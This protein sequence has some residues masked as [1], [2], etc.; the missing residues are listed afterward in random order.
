MS[1]QGLM[2]D[3]PLL[4]SSLIRYAAEQH[5]DREVVARSCEG[6]IHRTSWAEVEA[7]GRRLAQALLALGVGEG[8]RVATL[9]WNTHRHLEC[10]YG[11][12][13][14]GAVL[15][16]VNPRLFEEQIEYIVRHAQDRV[17][18][19]DLEFLPLVEK[20]AAR[21]SD[22]RHFVA[23]CEKQDLPVGST[24]AGLLS[25][26]EILAARSGDFTWPDFDERAASSLC[27]T[28]GTTGNP[29]GVLYSHRSTVL[30]ALGANQ[31][32]VFCLR[33]VDC[34]LGM[35]PLYHANGWAMPYVLPLAG[36]KYVLPGSKLEPAACQELIEGEAV[37]AAFAVPT[38]WTMMLGYLAQSGKRIESLERTFI[39]GTAVSQALRDAY[40]DEHGVEVVHLWG[41]T[42][43][44]PLGTIGTP[45]ARVAALPKE[46]RDRQLLKQGRIPFGVKM[47]IVGGDGREVQRD[48]QDFG[49]M[50]V[51]GPWIASGYFKGE[52]G[53]VLDA[54]GWFPTGDVGTFDAFG[55]MKITD[56]TKDVIKSGGE[57]I[58]SIDLEN[59][60]QAHPKVQ[61]AAAVAA[62]H[63]KWDERPIL[64]VVPTPG[65][66]VTKEEVLG[67]LEG[68]IA[69]WW[70]PDDVVVV[71][72][73]PMTATGKIRKATL[74]ER[75]W[76]HLAESE[77]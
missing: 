76:N 28:S 54:D 17:L 11:V 4:I 36:A 68:K 74:R 32:G 35:A 7:R 71:D 53:D 14:I 34:V 12:S 29:K 16:T 10:F 20:L 9:A 19:F 60:A 56:R 6:P 67:I 38:V 5:G 26:E 64:V 66:G 51:K 42:E 49:A 27:Y 63:P 75:F 62:Y 22:V 50:W 18:V 23:L 43:T 24:L 25:Y 52:G 73:L 33:P 2:Q 13:G 1:L 61:L 40:R 39:G 3:E 37:T 30:H 45:T 55:Y 69:K 77:A 41:M 65:Q 57:W 59:L 48:G 8:D 72:E 44:S 58:S 70:M 31:P 15:H 21:C 47:K 46:E